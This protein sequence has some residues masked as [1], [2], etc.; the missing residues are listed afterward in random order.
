MW[1]FSASGCRWL[2]AAG[3]LAVALGGWAA[4]TLP[5]RGGG[6]LWEPRGSALTVAGAVLA[7]LG[8]TL[9]VAA[10]WRYGVLL[11]RGV[12]DG[13]LRT[14]AW[15]TAPLLLAPPLYSADV[16]SYIAQGGM[17]LEGH[18]VYGGG[19]SVLGPGELG[20][21]AAAS[22]GGNWTDT[23]APYGPV[24][25]LLAEAVVGPTGGAIVPAVLGMRLIALGALALIVWAV[26]GLAGGPADR[27]G[28]VWLAALNPLLLIHVVG[29]MHNDGLMIG[30]MLGGVLLAA[31]G[32]WVLGCVLVGLAMM[33]KSPA[34][35]ALLFIGVM[36]AR[37]D[38]GGV[39]GVAKGLVL[40]GLVAGG[41]AAAATLAAGTGFGWLRTQSVAGAIH[42]ALSVTSDLGLAL[43]TLL[44]D[45]PEPVKGVVQKLGLLVAVGLILAL[46]WRA[47]KGRIDPV[48]GLGLSLVALV[49]LSPMVQPWYLLWGTV[50][51]AA[52]AWHSRAGQ[53]LAVF[54][55]A[56]VYETAPSGH[57][58]WYGFVLAGCVLALGLVWLRRDA[59]PPAASVAPADGLR[60]DLREA[61]SR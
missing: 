49:A 38:G 1:V 26:R 36:I 33:V 57:T 41:V 12:R 45:D 16:Y 11:A 50:V 4:G 58:P 60:A 29:G 32:R 30:L 24:F 5:V 56:L 15:W 9:L 61:R 48:L 39:R 22:V 55:A 25:L 52:V 2:G 3:S 54:S 20:A 14:L 42:T 6:G 47:W 13:V 34:V 53:V 23:P 51:V 43:G 40:P 8:L 19:P 21:D 44:A 7:Y 46:A 37:R 17:V 28:A 59:W 35:V 10:W 18:D 27:D 31:R